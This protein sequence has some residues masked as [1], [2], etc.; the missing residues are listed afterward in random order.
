MCQHVLQ[1]FTQRS[2]VQVAAALPLL[3]TQPESR[4]VPQGQ[5]AVDLPLTW[6]M[7]IESKTAAI[8]GVNEDMDYVS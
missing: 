8:T 3:P 4:H 5:A 1:R 2:A 7:E 6:Q